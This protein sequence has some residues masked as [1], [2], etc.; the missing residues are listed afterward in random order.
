MLFDGVVDPLDE[1][2]RQIGP[3][4]EIGHRGTVTK[5]VYCPRT[6]R[7]N[8]CDDK[9]GDEVYAQILKKRV[10]AVLSISSATVEEACR[11]H[12]GKLRF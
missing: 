10:R 2:A 8:T 5:R 1:H 12:N 11:M 7:S 6:A 3:P 4:E 9:Q